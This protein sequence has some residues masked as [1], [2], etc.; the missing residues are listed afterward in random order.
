MSP[1][2]LNADWRRLLAALLLLA[3]LQQLG[4]AGLI[5]AKAWLAPKLIER[6]W[7]RSLSAGGTAVKPWAWA[8][9]WPVARLLVPAL[10]V[11]LLVLA[12]DSGNALAFGPGH[13][14]A[15]AVLGTPGLAV[16]GGHRDTHFAFLQ[17]L[18][19][20]DPIMLQLPDRSVRR[21][22]VASLAVA[23]TR[24]Q[25]LPREVGAEALLL[26]TC[27][28]F[29]ALSANGPLRF[30]VLATPEPPGSGTIYAL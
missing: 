25:S 5:Q 3:A 21:Y 27:F 28:P 14:N 2:R 8:D 18:Q 16:V 7:T 9:T 19:S 23:D 10:G 15:S 24:V 17:R 22:R 4:A 12:G 29:N 30:V 11:N 13:A 26:V 1:I 20:G 6:A